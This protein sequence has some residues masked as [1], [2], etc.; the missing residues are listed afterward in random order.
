[1]NDITYYAADVSIYSV[2]EPTLGV[3]NICLPV[4]R[5]AMLAI[6]GKN[7]RKGHS[8]TG[9]PSGKDASWN[10]RDKDSGL[11]SRRAR[12]QG[13]GDELQLTEFDRADDEFPLTTCVERGVSDAYA[14]GKNPRE[15]TVERCWEIQEYHSSPTS[16]TRK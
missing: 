16:G 13:N 6:A 14:A 12:L 7:P 1:M 4:I 2:L 5:P 15:I 11:A 9:H 10:S 3:I 8:V